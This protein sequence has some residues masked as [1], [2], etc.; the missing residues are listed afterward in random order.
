VPVLAPAQPL[1]DLG[2]QVGAIGT[3]ASS[4]PV[5]A[6]LRAADTPVPRAAARDGEP[7]LLQ[8]RA[9]GPAE[10]CEGR[11]QLALTLCIERLCRSEP[12]LRDHADCVR[13]RVAR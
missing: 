2:R 8:T 3:A 10:R 4:A 11:A 5:V 13:A 1:P 12:G 7:V 6:A 9:L